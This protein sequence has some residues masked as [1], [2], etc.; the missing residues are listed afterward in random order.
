MAIVQEVERDRELCEAGVPQRLCAR[1]GE[2]GA[3]RDDRHPGD[4]RGAADFGDDLLEVG[5]EQRLASGERDHHRAEMARRVGKGLQLGR[6][7]RSIGFPVVAEVTLGV[8]AHGDLEMHEHRPTRQPQP[9]IAKRERDEV[10]GL[11]TFGE[12]GCL[13]LAAAIRQ[14]PPPHS[15]GML[16]PARMAASLAI[17]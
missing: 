6:A 15:I 3:M 14:Q 1:N 16:I 2:H 11:E 17:W 8:A 10:P 12:H 5:P 9:R 4:W 7:G 13:R